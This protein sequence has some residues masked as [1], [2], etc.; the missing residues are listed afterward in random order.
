MKKGLGILIVV[1]VV[2]AVTIL[3]AGGRKQAQVAPTAV[4]R[5]AAPAEQHLPAEADVQKQRDLTLD[6]GGGVTMKLVLIPAG[7]FMM[8][9][10]PPEQGP[11]VDERPQHR[12]RITKPFYMGVT[13]V[14]Q[15]QYKAVMGKQPWSRQEYAGRSGDAAANYISWNDA[16][17]F[18]RKLSAKI[19]QTVRLPTEAEWEYACRAGSTTAYCFGDDRRRLRD[20]AWY[21]ENAEDVGEKYPHS[22]A[23]K[24]PNA[25]GL[26]DMHGNLWEWCQDWYRK[27][28]YSK[29]PGADPGGP[30]IGLTRVLRGGSWYSAH[31]TYR[32]AYRCRIDPAFGVGFRVVVSP[33]P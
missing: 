4:T 2:G 10:P 22:V 7:E 33:P 9:S 6:L 13:E 3:L 28:Y 5:P 14:T 20:Y 1:V 16:R 29:S 17:E 21:S 15:E 18:C 11:H 12:V 31:G 23:K 25:W 30:S 27:D 8:G 32:C 19:G 26:Y 24:K